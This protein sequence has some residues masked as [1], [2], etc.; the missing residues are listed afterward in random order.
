MPTTALLRR[1]TAV[2]LTLALAVSGT[3]TILTE[4]SASAS[5]DTVVV[6][7]H[8][9]ND[10]VS[11]DHTITVHADG[12]WVQ[13][14][15]AHNSA[16]TRRHAQAISMLF[17]TATGDAR[18]P[19]FTSADRVLGTGLFQSDTRTWTDTG[20]D[21]GL[22]AWFPLLRGG[23]VVRTSCNVLPNFVFDV[24]TAASNNINGFVRTWAAQ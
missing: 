5:A 20:Q 12:S 6:V 9:V 2:M 8:C 18:G 7:G 14:V 17:P 22:V 11:I 23:G 1:R 16:V 19:R 15:R 10:H 21:P 13:H 4:Q 3:A 24:R